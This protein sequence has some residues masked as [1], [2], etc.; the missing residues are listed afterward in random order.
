M[1]VEINIPPSLQALVG[2]IGKV[3]VRGGTVG[4]CLE[5]LVE[6]YPALKEK[7]FN[8]KGKLPKGMNIFIN[9]SNAYPEPLARPVRDG[10]KIHI[11]YIVLGG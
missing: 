7:L 2:G 8:G 5:E 4:A 3:D 6:R 11:A 9:G 10:D 1:T